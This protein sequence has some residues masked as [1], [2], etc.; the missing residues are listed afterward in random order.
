MPGPTRAAEVGNVP[1]ANPRA[2]TPAPGRAALEMPDPR[3]GAEGRPT[4]PLGLPVC[5]PRAPSGRASSRTVRVTITANGRT[6]CRSMKAL[7][8][9]AGAGGGSGPPPPENL[10]AQGLA[11]ESTREGRGVGRGAGYA[12]PSGSSRPAFYSVLLP[13]P[14][15]SALE[16]GLASVVHSPYRRANWAG[17]APRVRAR[18]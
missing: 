6:K 1:P 14:R 10:T 13:H 8:V 16:R 9:G 4:P 17:G 7:R 18:R 15:K 2:G 5:C 3:P 11:A 12:S